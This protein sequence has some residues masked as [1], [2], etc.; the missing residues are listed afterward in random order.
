VRDNLIKFTE[1]C[2]NMERKHREELQELRDSYEGWHCC[3]S[4]TVLFT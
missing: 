1:M 4:C 3:V 2:E